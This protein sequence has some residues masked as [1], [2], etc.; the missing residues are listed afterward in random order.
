[1]GSQERNLLVHPAFCRRVSL[2]R[3]QQIG[4]DDIGYKPDIFGAQIYTYRQ[5]YIRE[6]I[7][8]RVLLYKWCFP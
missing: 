3:K 4:F 7:Q 1:M 8:P 6:S 2:E 5:E